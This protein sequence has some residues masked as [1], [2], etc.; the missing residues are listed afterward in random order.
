[1]RSDVIQI[2]RSWADDQDSD[3]PA[4]HALLI[5]NVPVYCDEDVKVPFSQR[6]QRPILLA[7]ESCVSNGLTFMT[8]VG[9]QEFDLPGNTLIEQQFHFKVAVKLVLASSIAAIASALVTLGKSSRNSDRSA[10]APD[11]L[12]AT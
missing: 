12:S 2:V 10:H 6:Q 8:A 4:R 7:A 5:P 1:M 11:S 9:K 3:G